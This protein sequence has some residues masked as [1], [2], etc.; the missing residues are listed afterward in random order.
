LQQ[1]QEHVYSS[2]T[3]ET[4]GTAD[5]ARS[6]LALPF[7]V[8]DLGKFSRKTA[9]L[10]VVAAHAL[11]AMDA[12][13]N[14]AFVAS[15]PLRREKLIEWNEGLAYHVFETTL[16]YEVFKAWLPIS[17]VHWEPRYEGG[18]QKRADLV[19]VDDGSKRIFEFKWWLSNNKMVLKGL[20]QDVDKLRKVRDNTVERILVGLWWGWN[21]E[22]DQKD[23]ERANLPNAPL[24]W[25]ARFPTHVQKRDNSYFAVAGLLV[26]SC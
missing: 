12:S 4:A 25:L 10:M 22:Q 3:M 18:S 2:I 15:R 9:Q 1:Q 11:R 6:D 8:D 14:A 19:V 20:R 23:I 7:F 26:D 5:P 17:S 24:A 16:V 13:L 21:W